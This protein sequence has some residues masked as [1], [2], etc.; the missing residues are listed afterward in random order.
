MKRWKSMCVPALAGACALLAS[1]SAARA[2]AAKD[3]ISELTVDQV[4][5]LLDKKEAS[6]F[7]N[8]SRERWQKS[9]LPGAKWVAFNQV[10]AQDLPQ[11]KDRKLVFYCANEL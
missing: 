4:Q 1:A 5:A 3:G 10:K 9:H 2:D 11:E 8:N 7:D 6:V